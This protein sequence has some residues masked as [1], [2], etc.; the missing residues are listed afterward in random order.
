MT[1]LF[2]FFSS[3]VM[4]WF[5]SI[6]FQQS[7]EPMPNFRPEIEELEKQS[8][9]MN[10]KYA[11]LLQRLSGMSLEEQKKKLEEDKKQRELES[12]KR[13]ETSI[14][15]EEATFVAQQKERAIEGVYGI[16]I[17]LSLCLLGS[18]CLYVRFPSSKQSD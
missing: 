12:K 11:P 8:L 1:G 18:L 13:V 4:F 9:D 16:M 3:L 7:I 14:K 15:K 17:A 5:G 2:L 6:A 10:E